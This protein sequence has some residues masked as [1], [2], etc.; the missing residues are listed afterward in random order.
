MEIVIGALVGAALGALIAALVV[1]ARA[2]GVRARLES[3]VA[4]SARR[5]TDLRAEHERYVAQ[6]RGDH[7]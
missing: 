7:E 4:A 5:E 6:L 3:E 2:S 1:G